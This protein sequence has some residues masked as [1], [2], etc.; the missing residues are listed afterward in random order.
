MNLLIQVHRMGHLVCQHGRAEQSGFQI[1]ILAFHEGIGGFVSG[2]TL[3][4]GV[5]RTLKR[6]NIVEGFRSLGVSLRGIWVF[7]LPLCDE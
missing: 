2:P 6:Q 3:L 1:R 4:L 5:G 7:S